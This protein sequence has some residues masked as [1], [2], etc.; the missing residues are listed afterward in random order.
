[1]ELKDKTFDIN[2]THK[3]VVNTDENFAYFADG[4][5]IKKEVLI[6]KY[7]EV[8]DPNAFFNTTSGLEGLAKDI[9]KIDSNAITE[10]ITPHPNVNNLDTG[11]TQIINNNQKEETPEITR[12][13]N[14]GLKPAPPQNEN[15]FSKIKRNNV[16]NIDFSVEEKFP[17]LEFVR[18]M[19]DNYE[20]SIIEH[21]A[22]EIV[23]K[24]IFDPE[25]LL[26]SIKNSI[27][28]IVYGK[29]NE[30]IANKEKIEN[31]SDGKETSEN[32]E[33]STGQGELEQ[34]A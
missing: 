7:E 24:M 28:E 1:M 13:D 2:N 17:E 18:M 10:N 26:E 27:T 34:E 22:R 11:T 3:K 33:S 5:R 31:E 19:N 6:T 16:I 23:E 25:I 9:N 32:T 21:F 14:S 12:I 15:F 20:T 29:D 30:E 8:M 4:A